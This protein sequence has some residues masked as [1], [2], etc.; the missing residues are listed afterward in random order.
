MDYRFG[1]I[2][3]Q[4]LGHITHAKNL[5]RNLSADPS[6]DAY[7]GL[8]AWDTEG[9]ASYIPLYRSN[10]TLRA[11]LRVRRELA[12]IKRK[13]QLDALFFH[14]Q[15]TAVLAQD[16]LRRI[17]SVVSLDATPIQYDSLGEFY[18]HGTGPAWLEQLKW[19]LNRDCFQKAQHLVAW[20]EWAKGGLVDGYQVPPD[21]VTVIPPGVNINEWQ[22]ER[23]ENGSKDKLK[24]LFVGGNLERKG[25]L[26]LLDAFRELRAQGC[27]NRD[28]QPIE[29]ELHLA[30]RDQIP[31]E[32]GV[33]VYNNMQPNSDPLKELYAQSDIFCLPTYG[34]CLPMV[35]SEA[36]A[37]GMPLVST[38]VAAIPE[39]VQEGKTGFLVPTGDTAALTAEL[40]KVITDG[41]LRM[42]MGRQA[43][44]VVRQYH[45]AHKNARQLVDLMKSI[46]AV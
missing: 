33:F 27:T 38:D 24:I 10:W 16:W 32:A 45:D 39:I 21:K 9:L 18:S 13:T 43:S 37:S 35:L 26:I 15:I 29:I 34:D 44:E 22:I 12:V 6:I 23:P 14:T 5:Q 11:G 40:R 46:A 36:G 3:E 30:T 17:P 8:P 28:G 31:P 19:R 7:W 1:F 2:I 42:R 25:G 20:S 4:T 41:D